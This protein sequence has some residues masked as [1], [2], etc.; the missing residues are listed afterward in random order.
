MEVI[1]TKHTLQKSKINQAMKSIKM[2][3]II[4]HSILE[5]ERIKQ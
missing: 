2:Y 3:W 1:N 5:G 4:F